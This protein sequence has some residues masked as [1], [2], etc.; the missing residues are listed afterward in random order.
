MKRPRSA[1]ERRAIVASIERKEA[2]RKY[3]K[4][5]GIALA[6]IVILAGAAYGVS[7]LPKK[8]TTVHWHA[9]WKVY[10]N[11]ENVRFTARSFDMSVAKSRIHLHLPDDVKLHLEGPDNRLTLLDLFHSPL[12]G[13]LSDGKMILPQGSSAPGT[14]ESNA[15]HQLHVYVK[16]LNGTWTELTHDI[17]SHSMT[18]GEKV[19][20][21][22]GNLTSAQIAQEQDSIPDVTGG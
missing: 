9:N 3:A 11:D 4:V 1:D 21:T 12:Q 8:P 19:L 14:Y 20:V 7:L 16:P 17:A 5:G 15:T 10:V 2:M 22:Y 6:A 13:E 18:D